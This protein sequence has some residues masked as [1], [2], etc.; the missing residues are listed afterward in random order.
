MHTTLRGPDLVTPRRTTTPGGPPP[1]R[2]AWATA[3][4]V[5]NDLV[6]MPGDANDTLIGRER[7]PWIH[8][9]YTAAN[10]GPS[11]N[12]TGLVNQVG[13]GPQRLSLH[14]RDETII[15][16][17]QGASNT[18]AQDPAAT[19]YG[20]NDGT[21]VGRLSGNGVV[22]GLHTRVAGSQPATLARTFVT[23]QQRPPRTNRLSNSRNAGQS[24]SQTTVHQGAR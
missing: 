8:A 3:N 13:S 7:M 12:S 14:M 22:H 19:G 20:I 6:R 4:G 5:V 11:T 16:H 15:D 10:P 21:T 23:P 9:G 18:R 1:G 17:V 2:R 24:Y